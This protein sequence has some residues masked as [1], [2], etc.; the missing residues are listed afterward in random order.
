MLLIGL[1]HAESNHTALHEA[2]HMLRREMLQQFIGIKDPS[3]HTG[4]YGKPYL[5]GHPE[6]DLSVSHSGELVICALRFP[7]TCLL[8]SAPKTN[9]LPENVSLS[10]CHPV[11]YKLPDSGQGTVGAD[12]ELIRTLNRRTVLRIA[13]RYFPEETVPE[14]NFS[15]WLLERWTVLESRCKCSGRGLLASRNILLPAGQLY[16]GQAVIGRESYI[17]SIFAGEA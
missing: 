10:R 4:T 14:E 8:P 15:R 17:F 3:W 13:S 1:S 11:F 2:G 9:S 7:E 6:T 12:A 16:T 5:A